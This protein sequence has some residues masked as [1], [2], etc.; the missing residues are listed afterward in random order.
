[1]DK[2]NDVSWLSPIFISNIL[3]SGYLTTD[4]ML[5]LWWFVLSLLAGFFS[6]SPFPTFHNPD[7]I[8]TQ[9]P[10]GLLVPPSQ[11]LSKH[12]MSQLGTKRQRVIGREAKGDWGEDWQTGCL[13]SVWKVYETGDSDSSHCCL[14]LQRE[15]G[16]SCAKT[17]FL[18]MKEQHH[19]SRKAVAAWCLVLMV[20]AQQVLVY[21]YMHFPPMWAD[22][23]E[24]QAVFN[25]LLLI[26]HVLCIE[27]FAAMHKLIFEILNDYYI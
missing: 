8:F 21:L 25:I 16:E 11:I 20:L 13:C 15:F 10:R 19:F 17:H 18:N 22:L 7:C 1:M 4:L 12:V 27:L 23:N 6:S 3:L 2:S 5:S 26:I 9:P 14:R 24:L